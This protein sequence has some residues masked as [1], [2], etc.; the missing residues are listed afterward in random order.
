[1]NYIIAT[2][3]PWNISNFKKYFGRNK[4]FYLISDP[5][6]LTVEKVKKINPRFIF[7]PHWSW[8]IPE[9][10]WR[11]FECVV[12]HETDLPYG[13]G[14]SPIQNLIVR[15]HKNTKISALRVD[16]GLDSGDIYMKENL[17]LADSAQEIFLRTSRI[18][19]S[20][21]MPYFVKNNPLPRP[22]KGKAVLFTRRKPEESKLIDGENLKRAY[23]K[24]RML[25]AQTYPK[26]FLETDKLKFDFS[27]AKVKDKK[28]IVQVEIYEK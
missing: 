17:S 27:G 7:F 5:K 10:I 1:M 28:I 11:N 16:A 20:K 21:M 19:F 3:K 9:E 8:I 15:R 24:I 22:Q 12:F 26:A 2:I 14:G 13:R 6:E 23:D 25:D 18:I 4:N